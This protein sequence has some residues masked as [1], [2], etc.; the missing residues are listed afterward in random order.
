MHRSTNNAGR[1]SV[2]V[3]RHPVY[4]TA[5]VAGL[6]AA[7]AGCS[8]SSKHAHRANGAFDAKAAQATVQ[9]SPAEL[10]GKYD[11]AFY[12]GKAREN[13]LPGVWVSEAHG[14]VAEIEA[15]RAAAQAMR[16]Q[17]DSAFSELNSVADA[18][19][20]QAITEEQIARANAERTRLINNA[21][22]SE[23][24]QKI[25][26]NEAA[27]ESEARLKDSMVV[28]L[29]QDRQ[30][31]FEK[32]RSAAGKELEQ[33]QAVHQ[34]MLAER[35]A[36]SSRGSAEIE[37]MIKVADM[38]E[39]KTKAR[40]ADYRNASA[41]IS[42]QTTARV[43]DLDQQ[44]RSHGERTSA[45]S[46]RFR[47]QA[48]AVEE[49][50]KAMHSEL[51]ARAVSLEE[52]DADAFFNASMQSAELGFQRSQADV[53]NSRKQARAMLTEADAAATRMRGE[54]EK[55]F[56]V[57]EADFGQQ[58]SAI[59]KFRSDS[60]AGLFVVR[61]Q[62]ER[63]ETEA[64]AQFVKAQA[65]ALANSIRH[66]SA[67]D[68][69]LSRTQ[70][71]QFKAQ[72][73]SEAAKIKSEVS[74]ALAAKL[75]QGSVE[76]VPTPAQTGQSVTAQDRSPT[77]A[78]APGK[79]I[80]VEPDH[81]AQFRTSIAKAAQLRL[82]ADASE[83]AMI[84]TW[85]ERSSQLES[86]WQQQTA[87]RAEQM[88]RASAFEQQA[89]AKADDLLAR[90]DSSLRIA[91]AEMTRAQIEAESARKET[92]A[93]IATLRA[94]A[95]ATLERGAAQKTDFLTQ[96]EAIVKSGAAEVRSLQ[97]QR[98]A[99]NKRGTAKAK[100]LLAQADALEQSQRAVVAQMRQ[101]IASSQ[102]ILK[103][104]LARLDQAATSFAQVARATF[105]EATT[106]AETF[107]EK[108]DIELAQMHAGNESDRRVAMAD[109]AH[110]RNLGQAQTLVGQ[111]KVDRMIAQA[112]N[113]RGVQE[114]VDMGRRATIL[115]QSQTQDATIQAQLA[116][117]DAT[118]ETVRSRFDSRVASV[119]AE[120][121]VAYAQKYLSTQET[122]ARV[123]Q[124]LAAANAYNNMS[125]EA[126]ASLTTKRGNLET[127]AKQNWD[128]RLAMPAT[129]TEPEF[130]RAFE[131]P[132]NKK[133]GSSLANVPTGDQD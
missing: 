35:A 4:I 130:Q 61:A 106:I 105:E 73:E 19:M 2:E 96:A 98:D 25:T 68:V 41:Q 52:G 5:L 14:A 62:A 63:V 47:Q 84:A 103:A 89:A 88:A 8:S 48:V 107:S 127:A 22:A 50:T 45:E 116:S 91:Q 90:A 75:Q 70:F 83:R 76:F 11:R 111:A 81:V 85:Q 122:N 126:L 27:F 94:E 120:R 42:Q 37:E 55:A 10:A 72:A 53:E 46:V 118:E 15:R 125:K 115:A 124:A 44:I 102:T 113:R 9:L 80:V 33:A 71:E 97:A 131:N 24:D 74:T 31:Q 39:A 93:Q 128:Q 65:E 92:L 49:Q 78:T 36:V 104:E 38:T 101:E 1:N 43:A 133:F 112:E 28:A 7:L 117:A 40:L 20:Q 69:T 67:Q 129:Y 26:A 59:D 57:S 3:V 13:N 56:Q 54:A 86:W 23:F 114:A 77:M 87:Q 18:D 123:Q 132:A 21:R 79:P 17:R 119:Q 108:A 29:R 30:A 58:R 109:I 16:V 100:E 66:Q 99:A 64:R 60:E 12:E 95:Q 51:L 110:M 121:N 32:M 6:A 34:R 82:E